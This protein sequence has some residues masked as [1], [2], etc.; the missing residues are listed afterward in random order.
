MP[1]ADLRIVIFAVPRLDRELL[2]PALRRAGFPRAEV[3]HTEDEFRR[4]IASADVVVVG[5]EGDELPKDSRS[6]LAERAPMKV[7]GLSGVGARAFVYELR[8]SRRL[9]DP[10]ADEL[11]AAIQNAVVEGP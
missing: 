7:L 3:L 6:Y 11:A 8:P 9:D 5:M 10:T 1:N 2:E 4:S